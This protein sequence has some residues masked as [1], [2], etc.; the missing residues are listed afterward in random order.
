M[1]VR[2]ARATPPRYRGA[3]VTLAACGLGVLAAAGVLG[4]GGAFSRT[5]DLLNHFTPIFLLASIGLIALAL[6][7]RPRRWRLL[8]LGAAGTLSTL[9]I[10]APEV[11]AGWTEARPAP[12]HGLAITLITQNI[13]GH[14]PDQAASA[15][16]LL[17]THADVIVLQEAR[18]AGREIIPLLESSYPYRADCTPLSEWCSMAILSK[19]PILTWSYRIGAW[20]PPE[21]DTL[22]LVRATI[23]GGAAGPFEVIGTQLLHPYP[24]GLAAQQ[25]NELAMAVAS[26]DPSRT[27]LVGDFNLTPWSFALKRIDAEIDLKR[28][29]RGLATW[30]NRLP[31]AGG[32]VAAPLPFLAIDQ[33]YAGSGWKVASITRAPRTASDHYGVLTRLVYQP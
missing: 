4:L 16:A 6:L 9:A 32:G 24:G 10:V 15:E 13:W 26:A 27:I 22:A 30:P 8:L 23:D 14:N 25:A 11:I 28:R 33:V 2:R 17:A 3:L 20:R 1:V 18:G 31:V 19:R 7:T 29:T 21:W 12:S 5:L